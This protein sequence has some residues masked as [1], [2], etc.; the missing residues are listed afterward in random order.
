MN[1]KRIDKKDNKMEE[2]EK[3]IGK[4]LPIKAYEKNWGSKTELRKKKSNCLK[5]NIKN[6][7]LARI[8]NEKQEEV[9][10]EKKIRD[11]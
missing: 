5:S 6:R 4:D 8:E 7:C 2:E 1:Y 10:G 9:E 11:M 3:K